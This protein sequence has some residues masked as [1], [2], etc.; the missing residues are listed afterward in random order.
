MATAKGVDCQSDEI[1]GRQSGSV[2]QPL[3]GPSGEPFSPE[4]R[5]V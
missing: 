5:S 1:R 3:L 2:L 4:T